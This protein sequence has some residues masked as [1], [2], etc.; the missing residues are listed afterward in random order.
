EV[1]GW[2]Q[3]A[4]LHPEARGAHRVR[5]A[6]LLSPFDSLV[7]ERGRTE[8]LFG[9]RYRLEIYVPEARRVH[10]YYVLPFLLD[11]DLVARVDLKADRGRSVLLVRGAYGEDGIDRDRVTEELASELVELARFLGLDEVEVGPRGDLAA[12]LAAV[13]HRR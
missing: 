10:G 2:Q 5:G 8:R 1:R 3:P 12:I 4:Y 11:G 13:V 6:A 7:W 9:F